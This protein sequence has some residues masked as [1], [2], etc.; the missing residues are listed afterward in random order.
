MNTINFKNNNTA[1]TDRTLHL[2]LCAFKIKN[3]SFKS[4]IVKIC[5]NMLLKF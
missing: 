5:K 1:N 2:K 4:E 3:M